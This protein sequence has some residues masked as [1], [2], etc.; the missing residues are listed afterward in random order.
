MLTISMDKTS[1]SG[2]GRPANIYEHSIF[3]RWLC[4]PSSLFL[5]IGLVVLRPLQPSSGIRSLSFTRFFP[6]CS[7]YLWLLRGIFISSCAPSQSFMRFLVAT[8]FASFFEESIPLSYMSSEPSW[9]SF[10]LV[11]SFLLHTVVDNPFCNH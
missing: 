2:F 8:R 5:V 3:C 1:K 7:G 11:T 10:I 6:L 9:I 4:G